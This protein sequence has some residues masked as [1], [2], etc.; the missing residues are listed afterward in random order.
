MKYLVLIVA[1]ATFLICCDSISPQEG[2]VNQQTGWEIF[3]QSSQNNYYVKNTT[4]NR[5]GD[6]Y[7]TVEALMLIK[8]KK[9]QDDE[10]ERLNI[11]YK[12]ELLFVSIRCDSYKM[13]LKEQRYLNKDGEEL[14]NELFTLRGNY[15][16]IKPYTN[17]D[18]LHKKICTDKN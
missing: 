18:V 6:K 2:W 3:F 12:S 1:V 8:Y 15:I 17:F 5:I 9:L 4:I 11:K 14:H 16:N 7:N 10:F 13:A